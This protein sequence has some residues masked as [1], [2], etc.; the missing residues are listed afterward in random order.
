MATRAPS[1]CKR[2]AVASPMP[3]FP[4]VTTATLPSNLFMVLS[5]PFLCGPESLCNPLACDAGFLNFDI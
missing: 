1:S 5:H 4:P 2:C 3:L